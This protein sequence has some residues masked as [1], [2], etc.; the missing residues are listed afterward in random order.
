MVGKQSAG[1]SHHRPTFETLFKNFTVTVINLDSQNI[2]SKTY[3][4]KV[5]MQN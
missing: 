3:L 2:I 4:K 1:Y 5:D